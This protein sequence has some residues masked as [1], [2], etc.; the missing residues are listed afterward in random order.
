MSPAADLPVLQTRLPGHHPARLPD[1]GRRLR[2]LRDE[3]AL[4]IGSG[5]PTTA[6][7]PGAP[8]TTVID[9]FFLGPAKRSLQ[10]A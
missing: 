6:C 9:G 8:P 3:G 1:P 5:F 10:V 7:A 2:P 4:V